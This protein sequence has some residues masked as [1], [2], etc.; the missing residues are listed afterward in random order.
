V[1]LLDHRVVEFGWRLP[2]HFKIRDGQNKWILRQ[3]LYR[4]VPREIVDRPKM[5]FS[6]PI[7]H[8]LRGALRPWVEELFA[9]S[10]LGSQ[11]VLNAS[12]VRTA[13]QQLLAGNDCQALSVWAVVM[14]QAWRRRWP[15]AE[16]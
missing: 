14:F 2:L 3:L 7:V 4:H 16:A 10:E 1:P 15:L 11:G 5:G 13:W 8:W 12:A 9:E 6:V